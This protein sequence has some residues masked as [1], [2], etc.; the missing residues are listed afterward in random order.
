MPPGTCT[1]PPADLETGGD[2]KRRDQPGVRHARRAPGSLERHRGLQRRAL[3][4]GAGQT[5][6]RRIP[7]RAQACSCTSQSS[8]SRT[9]EGRGRPRASPRAV[10]SDAADGAAAAYLGEQVGAAGLRRELGRAARGG[11]SPA[12]RGRFGVE[13]Q[14]ARR[15]RPGGRGRAGWR[16]RRSGRAAGGAARAGRAVRRGG[17]RARAPTPHPGAAPARREGRRR[18]RRAARRAATWCATGPGVSSAC[19]RVT[20]SRGTPR[21]LTAT[22]D[23][24]SHLLAL[25]SQLLQAAD[26]DGAPVELELVAHGEGAGCRGCRSPRCRC[27]GW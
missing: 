16:G 19:P 27:P 10:R 11:S 22:R 15:R 3:G 20:C 1:R 26:P 24:A 18:H 12:Q 8:A 21:R 6:R 2:G 14:D 4:L 5:R 25:L 17:G 23:T 9:S 7:M 13:H